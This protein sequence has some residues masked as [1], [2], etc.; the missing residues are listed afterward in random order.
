M[1]SASWRGLN[2]CNRR[3]WWW[4]AARIS[5][6]LAVSRIAS[7]W[8][9][10]E[11]WSRIGVKDGVAARQVLSRLLNVLFVERLQL[12]VGILRR[13]LLERWAQS[14][15]FISILALRTGLHELRNSAC[16]PAI[17]EIGVPAVSSVVTHS[18][19][20][21]VWLHTVSERIDIELVLDEDVWES[22]WVR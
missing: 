5:T 22:G 14:D 2:R 8:S 15:V 6:G 9:H 7:K 17:V 20:E 18:E 4:V 11:H 16:V 10:W 12:A 3:R 1:R 21:R 13:H 19:D